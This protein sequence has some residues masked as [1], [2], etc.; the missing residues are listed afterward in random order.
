MAVASNERDII[1]IGASAGGVEAL[2]T[3]F[4]HLPRDLRASLFVVLHSRS[5]DDSHLPRILSRAGCFKVSHP[6]NGEPIRRGVA[7]I[8]PKALH[9]V[10]NDGTV[11]LNTAPK[12]SGT[13]PAINPLFRSAALSFGPRVIGVV[14]TGVLD[15]GTAGL[16]EIKRR[17]G[18]A[19][20]QSPDDALFPGMPR[21]AIANVPV[22]HVV[23]VRE[24]GDLLVKLCA[25]EERT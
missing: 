24:M 14:L 6:K 15:D 10:L 21:S 20:V 4:S 12:E 23:P 13:R 7:Y 2:L 25:C 1:V 18:L 11:S 17:G 8:A 19:L 9:M 5:F 3:L 16:W 22:D